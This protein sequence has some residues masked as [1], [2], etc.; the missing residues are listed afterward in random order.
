MG[1]MHTRNLLAAAPLALSLCVGTVAAA[2]LRDYRCTVEQVITL[3]ERTGLTV[4]EAGRR[5]SPMEFTVDR[6]TGIMVG[7]LKNSW[8][9]DRQPRIVDPGSTE[10]SFKVVTIV[11]RNN[12]WGPGTSVEYLTIMEFWDGPMKGFTFITELGIYAG[13]CTHF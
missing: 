3:R 5:S 13:T 4:E 7:A 6:N 10:N 11:D 9:S 8:G 2:P 1:H 12:S